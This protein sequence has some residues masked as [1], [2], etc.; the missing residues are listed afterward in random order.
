MAARFVHGSAT[1]S[2]VDIVIRDIEIEELVP[3]RRHSTDYGVILS[4]VIG[5]RYRKA[6]LELMCRT[7]TEYQNFLNFYRTATNANTRFTFIADTTNHPTDTWSAFFVSEP[8]FDR[9]TRIGGERIV[10]T[11]SVDIQDAPVTL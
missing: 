2:T 11:F 3:T 6:S 4:Y 7:T 10:G 1:P 8:K 9:E 5:V